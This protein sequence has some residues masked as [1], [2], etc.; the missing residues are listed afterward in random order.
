MK[1]FVFDIDGTLVPF[2]E[3]VIPEPTKAALNALLNRGDIVC[4]ASGRPYIGIKRF[5]DTLVNGH[6]YIIGSNGAALFTYEGNKIY[7]STIKKSDFIRLYDRYHRSD[8][9]V[10]AYDDQNGIAYYAFDK[11]IEFELTVNHMTKTYKMT[12]EKD[13]SRLTSIHK[14]M[15]ASEP[16]VSKNIRLDD[17]DYH[18][19]NVM[20]SSKSYLEIL[21]KE[22]DKGICVD[23]LVKH[24]NMDKRDVF[25]FGDGGNDIGMISKYTGIAMENA[26]DELKVHAKHITK[27]VEEYG[28]KF[29]L[30]NFI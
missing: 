22:A 27:S 26:V 3:N 1:L 23:A 19:F 30:E 9:N 4:L 29:A 20:R 10:Y 18:Q 16:N 28:V 12:D 17:D 5:F 8:L 15:L 11:W 14:V 13:A 21:P 2:G 24:L 25:T 7:E 6:K